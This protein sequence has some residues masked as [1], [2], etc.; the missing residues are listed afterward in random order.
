MKNQGYH[1]GR[2]RTSNKEIQ[3]AEYQRWRKE[4][5]NNEPYCRKCKEN[6]IF[7]LATDLDHII[8]REKGGAVMELDNVQPLCKSCHQD[9]T[10]KDRGYTPRIEFDQDGFP[11]QTLHDGRDWVHPAMNTGTKV[12]SKSKHRQKLVKDKN[13]RLMDRDDLLH[14]DTE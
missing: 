1:K 10:E 9:K 4:V 11:I 14:K 3:T 8:P 5:L 12:A 7:E 13:Y 6:D 2:N